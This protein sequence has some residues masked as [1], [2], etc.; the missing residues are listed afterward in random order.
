M[1]VPWHSARTDLT[2][3]LRAEADAILGWLV[4]GMMLYHR[5]GLTPP[6][7]V[8]A[9]TAEYRD[10]SN[11]LR[12]WVEAEC[13]LDPDAVTTAQE[14][15]EAY[16]RWTHAWHRPK[17]K[18]GKQ[19]ASGLAALGCTADRTATGRGWQGIALRNRAGGLPL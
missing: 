19:W 12:E 11:P 13:V 2:A 3:K 1:F 9:A 4:E 16:E 17:V 5:E 14:L 15:R 18:Q 6:A 8:K 10:E 7:A